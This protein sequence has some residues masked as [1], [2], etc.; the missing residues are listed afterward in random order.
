MKKVVLFLIVL[1]ATIGGLYSLLVDLSGDSEPAIAARIGVPLQAPREPL[2]RLSR[3]TETATPA[4]DGETSPP[5]V[6]QLAERPGRKPAPA[7]KP[8]PIRVN[9]YD[10]ILAYRLDLWIAQDYSTGYIDRIQVAGPP[11]RP[12]EDG[13]LKS[14]DVLMASGWAGHPH[15]GLRMAHVLFAL[16]DQVIGIASVSRDHPDVAKNV[17][18]N[19]GRSGW[20]AQLAVAHMPDCAK[21]TLSAWGI[22]SNGRLIWPLSGVVPLRLPPSRPSSTGNLISVLPPIVPEATDPPWLWTVDIKAKTL[23]MRQ[24]GDTRCAVVGKVRAGTHKEFL[25][26]REAGWVLLQFQDAA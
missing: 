23:N 11:Q 14:T 12:L 20:V 13:P 15:F 24:C 22:A 3:Q 1:V 8:A 19:L 26:D 21:P 2:D 4:S 17:H 6:P 18:P 7:R 5:E 10:P 16:C 25:S 9:S